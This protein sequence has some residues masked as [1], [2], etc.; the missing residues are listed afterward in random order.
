MI[1]WVLGRSGVGK[2][3]YLK[4]RLSSLCGEGRAV[5]YL[6]PEQ[7]SMALERAIGNLGLE[8][9]QVVSFRRLTNV[10]FR[11]LGGVAGSYMT[12]TRETALI[13][14]TLLSQQK[15]L[16]Y[17]RKA[18]P[19]MGFIA[20][21]SQVFEE[22][23]LSGLQ[24]EGVIPLLEQS[25]RQDWLEKYKDLFLLYS[26]YCAQLNEENRSAAKELS[27]A[28]ELAKAHAFFKGSAVIID[29]FFGFTGGQRALIELMMEQAED[30][31]LALT[32]DPNDSSLLF[33]TAKEELALL[34][35]AAKAKGVEQRE[36]FLQGPSKRLL[37]EDLQ[38][39][40]QQLFHPCPK[41]YEGEMPHLSLMMGKN[42]REELTMV[43]ADINRRVREEGLRYREIAVIAGSL[44]S[45]GPI[46]QV[47]FQRYHIPLFLDRGQQSVS[48]PIF[49]FVRSAL[50]L[51]SPER[52][53][54]SE[55]ML[56]FLKTGMAGEDPDLISRLESYCISWQIHG[57]KW[58]RE[59]PFTQNP[60][61]LRAPTE[62][63]EALLASLNGLRER[64][65]LPLIAFK[66]AAEEG[67]GEAFAK[68]IYQLLSDFKVE[69]QISARAKEYRLLAKS[70]EDHWSAQH[71]RRMSREYM[72]HYAAMVEILDDLF[73][74]FGKEKISLYALEELVGLCG[75]ETALNVAPQSMD[76]VCMGEVAHSRLEGIKHLYVVGANQGLLP[77]P[78]A[79]GGLIG[80][81]E[82]RLFLEHDLPCNATLQQ[83]TLQGQYRFYSALFSASCGL[84][85]SCSAF[86]MD[87][88][89]LLPSVYYQKLCAISQ[90]EPILREQMNLYDF[91]ATKDGARELMAF[92]PELS[93]QIAKEIGSTM[94]SLQ[95]Q[96]A[97]LEEAVVQKMFGDRLRLSYS[98]ISLYQNCPFHYF[99]EKTLRIKPNEPIRFDAANIGTFIHD[100]MEQL[101]HS[102]RQENL[103]Y[104]AYTPER[105]MEFGAAMAERYLS[106]QLKD[107]DRSNRFHAL[108]R[109][110]TKL[111]CY[112]AENVLEELSEGKFE[113]Y[114]A[115]VSLGGNPLALEGGKE[116]ELIGYI[117]RVDTY[118]KDGV[119]YLKV[120]DYKTG[121]QKF[122]MR[123]IT[124]R[125]GV[126]LPIYLYGLK[127]SGKFQNP[128]SA[129]ACYMEAHTPDFQGSFPKEELPEQIRAFYRRG[130]AFTKDPEAL[131]ALDGEGGS[132][133]FKITYNKGGALGYHV[134]AYEPELMEEMVDH[135]EAVLKETAQGIFD[136]NVRALPLK[137]KDHDACKYCDFQ[138]ICGYDEQKDEPRGWSEEPFGWRR[139]EEKEG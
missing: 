121:S 33:S 19:T 67:S 45:Y 98:Q 55:D 107:M 52:Y 39:L 110:M 62:E 6:V 43:A 87:G 76:A 56:S 13:Y 23:S 139:K 134:K 61:G 58:I 11:A 130:G 135:M 3:E 90:K 31:L 44:D 112:V 74:V 111:F 15:K 72:Q 122:D 17:Y 138:G 119:T 131:N 125:T 118:E 124:N 68:G 42:V 46:S 4:N 14:R 77:M 9:V 82:R 84:T 105:I 129:A 89:P 103:N 109:R 99:M 120:T 26:A 85:F 54:R 10:I 70:A 100:G 40:E 41:P 2:T 5:Y 35:R 101:I 126:Q 88:S 116:V 115:E 34:K 64:V 117:D 66:R 71:Y 57:E 59:Q 8:G 69:E 18:R 65:R 108:Y 79:D 30:L 12:K 51:I 81:R 113:P 91:A 102:L 95:D 38:Y 36:Q 16:G 86:E 132:R 128:R 137:G 127:K 24:E 50:R 27:A 63:G 97:P 28:A 73:L 96:Q 114:G 1:T 49:S 29:G 80:D 53:F 106:E 32:L 75:E 78:A 94:P 21:L 133:H 25:G 83:N 20:K 37:F 136:G 93:A 7:S 48:K 104:K 123:G 92:A 22:F 60:G 47:I